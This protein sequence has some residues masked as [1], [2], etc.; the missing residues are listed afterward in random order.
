MPRT[1][2]P[3]PASP[4]LDSPLRQYYAELRA[5]P[6]SAATNELSFRTPLEN[7]L[8]AA[9][10]TL[11]FPDVRF[12]NEPRAVALGRPDFKATQNNGLTEIGYVEAEAVG[13][14]LAALKDSAKKQNDRFIAGLPNFLQTNHTHFRLF[15]NGAKADE[16]AL[17][18]FSYTHTNIPA[19]ERDALAALLTRFL[20]AA[21]ASAATSETLAR[22]L[23][24]RASLLRNGAEQLLNS[25]NPAL[26]PL[27]EAYRTALS[28][29]VTPK[30]FADVYAQTF[31]YGL[32]L[33]W[34]RHDGSRPFDRQTAQNLLPQAVGPIRA[35][36]RLGLLELPDEIDWIVEGIIGDLQKADRAAALGAQRDGKEPMIHFYE[37]FL[38]AYDKKLRKATGTYYTPEAVTDFIVRAVDDL[39]ESPDFDLDGGIANPDV[40]LLDPATGTGTFLA[41][42]IRRVR[43]KMARVGDE[44]L[45]PDRARS[46]IVPHFFGFEL[47]P[48]AYTLAHLSLRT[49]LEKEGVGLS[50]TE[51]LSVYLANTLT[52]EVPPQQHLLL[53]REFSAEVH[54]ADRVKRHERI[55]VVL[56][57]PPYKGHSNNPSTYT[58]MVAPGATYTADLPNGGTASRVNTGGKPRRNVRRNFIGRLLHEYYFVDGAPLNERNPKWL[59]NDYMKF[60]RFAEWIVTRPQ[61]DGGIVAFITDNSYLDAPTFRGMR[62]HLLQ[63]FDTLYILDLHGNSKKRECAPDGSADQ[64]VFDITQGVSILLAVKRPQ[65]AKARTAQGAE[66][67][68]ASIFG[69]RAHKYDTLHQ[70]DLQSTSWEK[71]APNAPHYLFVPHDE[72]TRTEYEAG[73]S[74]KDI[75]PVHVLGFQTHRDHFAID[76]DEAALRER[77]ETLR[78]TTQTDDDIKQRYALGT[79]DVATARRALRK[80]AKWESAFIS[81]VYSPFDNRSCYFATPIMD[82]PR[83]ELLNHVAGRENLVLNLVRQTRE[84]EWHHALVTNQPTPAVFLEVK[85]GSSVFPLYLYPSTGTLEQDNGP[86]SNINSSFITAITEG[87]YENAAEPGEEADGT[88]SSLVEQGSGGESEKTPT[89][90]T[91]F[92]YIYAILHAPTY[93]TRYADFLKRDFP[94]IPLPP[95]PQTLAAAAA[96]G[97]RLIAL[98]LLTDPTLR[99]HGIGY[100]VSGNHKVERIADRYSETERRVHLNTNQYF[101]NVPPEAW[102]F[103]IGGYQPAQKWLDDRVGRT[104]SEA[105]INHYRRMIAALRETA[106]L[107]PDCDNAFFL[108]VPNAESV[109]PDDEEGKSDQI[110]L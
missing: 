100:P 65:A 48:A 55:I 93:R 99:Q 9:A 16:V 3:L 6:E 17:P 25:G 104:L 39:L 72:L 79:F 82:R 87:W 13:A 14:N 86:R 62:R 88:D 95:D 44:A 60:I 12:T 61:N 4:A 63:T 108:I 77:I 29:A 96:L 94:H 10:A 5:V 78:D 22:L 30:E 11:G 41:R 50:D 54:A 98:H 83:V 33:A 8:N 109:A 32:F 23:A 66:V 7:F 75:F 31:A 35:L 71:L 26:A 58:E 56:G 34:M 85:E 80:N 36:I 24:M 89:P 70:T 1:V 20:T 27:L 107:L 15:V 28:A 103:R 90:E 110:A 42:A 2:A 64:N 74:V 105:D 40:R 46:H 97:E 49:L 57:N 102:N 21:T 37:T 59:Q 52:D 101:E 68:H 76:F 67:Y 51:R 47:L 19:A 53:A 43:E 92:Q 106:R 69:D 38:A 84:T 91:L 73:W 18:S 45:F 81:C